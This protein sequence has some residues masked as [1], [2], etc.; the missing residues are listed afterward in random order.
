MYDT[1]RFD[2]T[3]APEEW[4]LT[5]DDISMIFLIYITGN[6]ARMIDGQKITISW[7][8]NSLR[9]LGKELATEERKI[10]NSG[11]TAHTNGNENEM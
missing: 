6:K 8:D 11:N 1:S 4:S 2:W 9:V 10:L 5:T 7:M 3:I